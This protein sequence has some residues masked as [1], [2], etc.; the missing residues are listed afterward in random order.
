MPNLPILT[1]LAG[2]FIGL[3]AGQ[4]VFFGDTV[5]LH[6]NV[7]RSLQD[8]GFT[9]PVAEE[10]FAAEAARLIRGRSVIP[11]P[12]LRIHAQPTV[13][14]AIAAPLSTDAAVAAVQT[15]FGIAHLDVVAAMTVGDGT[16]GDDESNSGGGSK[17]LEMALIISQPD[18]PPAEIRLS[19]EDGNP[20]LLVRRAAAWTLER[21]APYRVALADFLLGTE[22]DATG[23]MLARQVAT[24]A[25][26]R[27]GQR[28]QASERALL[29]SLLGLISAA[30]NDLDGALA[31]FR[32][33]GQIPDMLDPVRAEVA[34]NQAVVALA[35]RQPGQ[36]AAALAQARDIA[37]RTDLPD[38]A[39]NLRL[40]EGL[41]AWS[42]GDVAAAESMFREIAA[43]APSNEAGHRYLGLVLSARGDRDGAAAALNAAT[44]VHGAET[45]QQALVTA[46]F[47]VDPVGG[48]LTRR[49]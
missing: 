25:L 18:H 45:P 12:T 38:L 8:K 3:F 2:L 23:F 35:L 41:L 49:F 29:T 15:Q 1:L 44:A 17:A 43:Q 33:A 11:P 19:Q 32:S 42:G 34:L 47:W 7:P 14:S 20:V 28:D 27:P 39:L 40:A 21:V 48:G 6:I 22:G 37:A 31:A 13:L 30:D 10:V 9:L 26:L 24:R 16:P 36:A 5:H 4:A 46:L